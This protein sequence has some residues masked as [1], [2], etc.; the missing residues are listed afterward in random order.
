MPSGLR[1]TTGWNARRGRRRP[2]A[3]LRPHPAALAACRDGQAVRRRDPR[4]VDGRLQRGDAH[5]GSLGVRSLT[6]ARLRRAHRGVARPRRNG[7]G[8]WRDAPSRL[9]MPSGPRPLPRNGRRSRRSMP[10]GPRPRPRTGRRS[11]HRPTSSPSP[12]TLVRPARHPAPPHDHPTCTA[13]PVTRTLRAVTRT[14]AR[15]VHA[16]VAPTVHRSAVR[17]SSARPTASRWNRRRSGLRPARARRIAARATATSSSCPSTGI[18]PGDEIDR[19]GEVAGGADDRCPPDAAQ[20]RLAGE[21]PGEAQVR[22][23]A[24]Q[25][26][27]DAVARERVVG[28]REIVDRPEAVAACQWPCARADVDRNPPRH[29]RPDKSGISGAAYSPARPPPAGRAPYGAE[30]DPPPAAGPAGEPTFPWSPPARRGASSRHRTRSRARPRP[31]RPRP[32]AVRGSRS[33]RRSSPSSSRA[34]PWC[35]PCDP[36]RSS[37]SM[38]LAAWPPDPSTRVAL[39]PTG[40]AAASPTRRRG[41]R[42]GRCDRASTGCPPDRGSATP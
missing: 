37:A 36:S 11:R 35:S 16:V 17:S 21:A 41:Q 13:R 3:G 28:H 39:P 30:V 9:W 8:A 25:H 19:R 26:R 38:G 40:P 2:T 34:R 23:H 31:R 6:E 27:R 22:G 33:A 5:R 7:R 32:T 42:C 18:T 14:P 24:P 10:S 15:R 29:L 12:S 1:F 4:G 20:E